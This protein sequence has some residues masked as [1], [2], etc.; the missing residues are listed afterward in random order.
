MGAENVCKND[1]NL[2][3]IS[4]R[5]KKRSHMKGMKDKTQGRSEREVEIEA[6]ISQF[7]RRLILTIVLH[8]SHP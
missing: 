3:T 8:E 2:L 7:E 5:K 6:E 1:F 4:V